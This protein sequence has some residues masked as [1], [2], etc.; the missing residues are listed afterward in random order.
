MLSYRGLLSW[1]L[2][3][4][5]CEHSCRFYCWIRWL[6]C[7]AESSPCFAFAASSIALFRAIYSSV[8]LAFSLMCASETSASYS[9][10]RRNCP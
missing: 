2:S 5:F 4:W 8:D 7:S 10:M 9:E 6:T 1:R 3:K